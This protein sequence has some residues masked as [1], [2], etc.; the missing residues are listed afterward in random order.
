MTER[1]DV[2]VITTPDDPTTDRLL[3]HLEDAG[4]SWRRWDPGRVPTRQQ[5]GFWMDGD[6][7]QRFTVRG[8][9]TQLDLDRVGVL[10]YRRPSTLHAPTTTPNPEIRNFINTETRYFVRGVWSTIAAPIVCDP[11]QG[12]RA[13]MKPYQLEVA[14]KLGW[15]VPLTY[16]GNDPAAVRELFERTEGRMI[17]KGFH[18]GWTRDTQEEGRYLYTAPVDLSDLEDR[19]IQACPSIWQAYVP[20]DVELRVTVVG[21]EVHAAEIHSQQSEASRHDWRRYDFDNTP[22][23]PHTLPEEVR[24]RCVRLV[25][26][27]GLYYGAIDLI[28]TPNGR[29]VFLEVNPF[30]QWGWIEELCDLPISKAHVRLFRELI[31]GTFSFN[32]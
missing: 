23:R 30:G 16:I 6:R 2:L 9:D 24:R 3:P 12:D 20:K 13:S 31:D 28:L 25:R 18:I 15:S 19:A 4:M 10:W 8:D 5:A 22:Y 32:D 26:A 14:R 11:R 21:N 29:H 7:C 27:L 17:V 1:C